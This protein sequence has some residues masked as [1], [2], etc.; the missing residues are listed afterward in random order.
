[1]KVVLSIAGSDSG[2]GAGIQADI[3]SA[4]YHGV[5]MA[6]ALTA[7]TAQN[8]LGVS[9]IVVLEPQFVKEQIRSV[10]EDFEVAA[11]KIGMLSEVALIDVVYEMLQGLN[12]PIVLDPVAIS[13]AGSKLISDD[14]IHALIK[15]FPLATLITPNSYEAKLFFEVDTIQDIENLKN[16]IS[17]ILFKNMQKEGDTCVDILLDKE[18]KRSFFETP[19]ASDSNTHGTGCSFSSSIA[20][21]LA[22]G[23]T[24]EE[25]IQHSKNYIYEAISKAPNLGHG[26][27][28][29]NHMLQNEKDV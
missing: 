7:L 28:P 13:R 20:S 9:G 10:L 16:P 25:S 11:I 27:G 4:M 17:N 24:L 22:R 5:Y 29:I 14:A 3:K 12:I 23:K 15:L 1:M 26:N 21:L 18:A 8:T 2:G 6:T 19:R